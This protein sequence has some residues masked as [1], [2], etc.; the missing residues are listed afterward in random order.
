MAANA[1]SQTAQAEAQIRCKTTATNSANTNANAVNASNSNTTSAAAATTTTG[2]S[3]ATTNTTTNGYASIDSIN[4]PSLGGTIDPRRQST[5]SAISSGTAATSL[6]GQLSSLMD[7][8]IPHLICK[9]MDFIFIRLYL[10][11]FFLVFS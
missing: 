3:P 9:W 5:V 2:A 4:I 11:S 1:V 8:H 10:F 7:S 6:D